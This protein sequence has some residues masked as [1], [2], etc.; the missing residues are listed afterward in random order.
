[1]SEEDTESVSLP[2]GDRLVSA[3]VAVGRCLGTLDVRAIEGLAEPERAIREA[4]IDP[5]G[6]ERSIFEVVQP[7]EQVVILVSDSFRQ[8]RADLMLPVLI[9]GL[10]S[11]GASESDLS[12]LFSTGTHRGPTEDEQREILGEDVYARMR[13][14]IHVHD[15]RDADN[16]VFVGTTGRGTPVEI[17]RRVHEADRVIVTG[18]VVLHYFGGFGGGRKSVVPGVA[19]ARTISHNH[20]MNL[21]ATEDRLDPK[22]RIGMLAGN[23]VAEDMLEATRL[24]HADCIVNTVLN[25]DGEIAG[26]FAGELEAAHEAACAFARGLFEVPIQ[27]RA[28]IVIAAS[29]TTKNFVQTHKALFNAFQA[30]APNGRVVLL[31]PCREGLGEE[32]FTQ[33]LKLGD[34]AEII[35]ALRR[36]SEINGQT[37]LSTREKAPRTVMVTELS[38][39]DVALLG[40]R[41]AESLQEAVD[42]VFGDLVRAG[43][44]APGY[45]LMPTAAYTVPGLEREGVNDTY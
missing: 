26:V 38:D 36:R 12:I 45:Y 40:A 30:V 43:I 2:Y 25:R 20:A 16:H 39:E 32:Q 7:G 41:R 34:R 10:V 29:P 27:E 33:W 8:T 1:M 15:A 4:L 19:S 24:T 44:D 3:K 22:V 6:L 18:S 14:R 13:G 37:A 35:A 23:P 11:A 31:A 21:H 42:A 17:N 28:D 9:D 5:I